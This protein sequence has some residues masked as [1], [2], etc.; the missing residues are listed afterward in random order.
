[1]LLQR[2]GTQRWAVQKNNA[3]ETGSNVGSDFLITRYSDGGSVIDNA[4][5]IARATGIVT[6]TDGLAIPAAGLFGIFGT[7]PGT[8]PTV[9]GSRG[10]ATVAV[11]ASLLTALAGLGII[12]NQTTA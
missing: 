5:S 12:N 7:T 6:L 4:V 8:Q 9:P 10:S 1:M 11:L 2:A 3:T